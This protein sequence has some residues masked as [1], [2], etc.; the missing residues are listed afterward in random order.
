MIEANYSPL[1]TFF[2]L[3]CTTLLDKYCFVENKEEKKVDKG[4]GE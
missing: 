3:K 1:K 2:I 4:V